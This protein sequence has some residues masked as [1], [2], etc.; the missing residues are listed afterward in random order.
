MAKDGR[1]HERKYELDSICAH[2]K[3]MN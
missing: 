1:L 2:L 3:L